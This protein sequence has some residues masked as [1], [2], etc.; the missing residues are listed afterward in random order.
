M[1]RWRLNVT[2]TDGS[3]SAQVRANTTAGFSVVTY[4]GAGSAA[5]IGSWLG[6]TPSMIIIKN[7]WALIGLLSH[8]HFRQLI[9]KFIPLMQLMATI[10]WKTTS[11]RQQLFT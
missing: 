1:E 4:T 5:T 3:I 7:R 8:K 9:S 6:V 10:M 11:N 2:N